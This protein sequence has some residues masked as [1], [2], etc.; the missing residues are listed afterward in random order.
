ME[1]S[2][3]NI[4]H[5]SRDQPRGIDSKQR[6]QQSQMMHSN[7]QHSVGVGA[8]TSFHSDDQIHQH[9]LAHT[10]LMVGPGAAAANQ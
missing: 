6:Q 9:H 10:G 3:K 5:M 4:M 2:N 7:I 8:I 1:S